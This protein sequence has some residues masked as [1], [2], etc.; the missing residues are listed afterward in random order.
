MMPRSFI[1][2]LVAVGCCAR[3]MMLVDG[4]D[5]IIETAAIDRD[6]L[7]VELNNA[8]KKSGRD[9]EVLPLCYSPTAA[10]VLGV[11]RD[12]KPGRKN[13][14][15]NR[16]GVIDDRGE[17]G[18]VGS[19]D[20]CAGPLDDGYDL[21]LNDPNSFAISTGTYVVCQAGK[22]PDRYLSDRWGW[23]VADPD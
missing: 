15:D 1:V 19:D 11:G 8:A 13:K 10:I 2:L 22:T 17:L 23:F 3:A 21:M 9:F 5:G 4:G 6:G 7:E 20:R 12:G 16:N 14:D 18:A